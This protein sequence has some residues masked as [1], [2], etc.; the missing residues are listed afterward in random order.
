MRD[1]IDSRTQGGTSEGMNACEAVI[2]IVG[3][4]MLQ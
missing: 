1:K 3:N 2:E 4:K